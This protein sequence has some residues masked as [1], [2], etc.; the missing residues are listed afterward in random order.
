VLNQQQSRIRVLPDGAIA[1]TDPRPDLLP[2]IQMFDPNFTVRTAPLPGFF[3]PHLLDTRAT[4]SGL[5][6]TGMSDSNDGELWAA[7]DRALGYPAPKE[8]DEGSLLDVKI[9]LAT[10]MLR[11]C[12]LCALRCGVNRLRGERGRCGLGA[13]AFVYESYTHIAEEPPINPAVNL[14]LRGCG[15]RCVYCQQAPALDPRGTAVEVLV[16][17]FWNR[18]DFNQARSLVF[19]GGNPTESLPSVLAFLGA[20]PADFDLPIGWNCSGYDSPDA[21]RLL[22][23]VVDVYIPDYKY[24]GDNCATTLSDA[25][26]YATNVAHAIAA[27]L[28]Q[29]VPVMVRVL[30]LP[31]HV[32]CCHSPALESLAALSG[33]G[34]LYISVQGTYLPEW[35]TLSSDS[36]LSRRPQQ[37]EIERVRTR[38]RELKLKLIE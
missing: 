18:L 12:E 22:D 5:R 30:V 35:K 7:H 32:E 1:F 17:T 6:M 36:S 28:K 27:M 15:M 19:I 11:H 37:E 34:E 29:N 9:E 33:Y 4:G 23:G 24:A 2:L 25:A 31:D 14:S 16:P 13:E 21:I 10:R 20:A 38:A 26:G 8:P 3:R